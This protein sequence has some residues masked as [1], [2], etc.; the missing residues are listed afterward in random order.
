MLKMMCVSMP[1]SVM[2]CGRRSSGV[3]AIA[4]F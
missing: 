1:P 3:M 4:P 2:N